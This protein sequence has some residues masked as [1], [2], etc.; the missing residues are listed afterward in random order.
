MIHFLY[1]FIHIMIN[2]NSTLYMISVAPSH[3][4]PAGSPD[5]L[6]FTMKLGMTVIGRPAVSNFEILEMREVPKNVRK[7]M[8]KR[9]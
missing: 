3:G 7:S 5:G 6:L 1:E 8:F 2:P 4:K 9:R